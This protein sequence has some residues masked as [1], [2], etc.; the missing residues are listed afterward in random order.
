MKTE[1]QPG[2]T[3]PARLGVD[4]GGTF[5]DAVLEVAGRRHT[6]KELTT[7]DAPER[8]ALAAIE[9]AVRAAGLQPGNVG[10]VI[11][12]TT[13]ATNALLE[14]RGA[15]TAL[16]TTRGFRDVLQIRSE[17]RYEQYD[18]NIRLP[19]P[20]VPRRLR[21]PVTERIDARGR[22]R[23]PLDEAEVIALLPALEGVEAVAIGFLHSYLNDVHERRVGEMLTA[24]RPDLSIT[25]SSE[26]S[27]EMREYERFSTACANAYIQPLM[28]RYLQRLQ[29]ELRARN[30]SCPLLLI[31]SGGGLATVETSRRYPVR[32]V[33]SG[34]AGGAVFSSTVAQELELDEALSFDMGGTTAKVCL[35]DAFRPQLG[36][37]FEVAR[38]WRFR[39]GS[40]LPLRIPCVE[41]V[42]IGA[43]G[44]SIAA[45]DELGSIVVGPESSGSVPGPACYGKGG[46][47]P[48][49]T[50]ADL[51]LGRI[52]PARFANG[53]IPLDLGAAQ[54]ALDRHVAT[55]LRMDVRSGAF[56]VA[57]IVDENMANAARV[58]AIESG[59]E[60]SRRTLIAFGGAAPL[61]V[62]RVAEKLG[63][64]RFVVPSGAGVGSAIGF[65]R[66][67]IA[68][69]VVRTTF[70]TLSGFDA[71]AT[72]ALLAT[73]AAEAAAVVCTA[74]FGGT[75]EE[76][77]TVFM[78]YAGQGYEL[79]IDAPVRPY[80]PD[81]VAVLRRAFED[82]YRALY[83]WTVPATDIEL[84]GWSVVVSTP[85][86]ALPPSPGV[87]QSYCP[88]PQGTQAVHDPASGT[89]VPVP[90]FW[91]P[92][93]HPGASIP[94]P[95]L[96]A[97]P[98][99][100]TWLSAAFTAHLD[101]RG[102]IVCD[103]NPA[104]DA[105]G[106]ALQRVAEGATP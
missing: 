26:V 31:H 41:L 3:D 88:A 65:L 64:S 23:L 51:V 75:L 66:A 97:E 11:H 73:M 8:G 12:G 60:V 52:D 21:L 102:Y 57:E 30:Y 70:H 90:V 35:I 105:P 17:D 56:G 44:G 84:L 67:P 18:L 101:G 79:G 47:R 48:A 92:D 29:D 55:P 81:D 16:V 54:A 99:T 13:L 59:K 61:H 49:V 89:Q 103:R 40:G 58:H 28:S 2:R 76:R 9:A 24:L 98:E 25:L 72:T 93:L 100:T 104:A 27:P 63:V 39:K 1:Q 22:V 96:I 86:P 10:L 20:L 19:E 4:I 94:G 85:L 14:R 106:T 77:R 74:A 78:R 33:E 15:R 34:P 82:R 37:R 38:V 5:T 6:W 45:L 50:D 53:A 7:P 71:D 36:R 46:D 91:R 87:A 83:S 68:Y 80:T 43:G 62:A 42:E 95:A 32:L 69:E